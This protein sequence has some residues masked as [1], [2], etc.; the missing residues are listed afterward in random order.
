MDKDRRKKENDELLRKMRDG[1]SLMHTKTSS[2]WFPPR[3]IIKKDLKEQKRLFLE[4]P[5]QP[6][7]A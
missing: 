3:P 2:T 5:K 6:D 4:E 1:E 7:Q